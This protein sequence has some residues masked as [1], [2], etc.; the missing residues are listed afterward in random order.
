MARRDMHAAFVQY[1]HIM[2][3]NPKAFDYLA[4][5]DGLKEETQKRWNGE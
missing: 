3:K 1:C 4:K 5:D 2:E